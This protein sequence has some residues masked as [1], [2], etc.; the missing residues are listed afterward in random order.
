[1]SFAT[2]RNKVEGNQ[3]NSQEEFWVLQIQ[4]LFNFH[5]LLGIERFG[6]DI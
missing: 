3:Y 2:I 1:M 6:S 4:I 5:I